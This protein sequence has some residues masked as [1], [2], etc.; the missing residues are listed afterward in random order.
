M[1]VL[2]IKP[3]P[4]TPI[5]LEKWTNVD[6]IY[7][8]F[9]LWPRRS[10]Y[11]SRVSGHVTQVGLGPHF[12]SLDKQITWIWFGDDLRSSWICWFFDD[13][14][15]RVS[16][17]SSVKC[18]GLARCTGNMGAVFQK[19]PILW[20]LH[21]QQGVGFTP[22]GAK[23]TTNKNKIRCVAALWGET[24]CFERMLLRGEWPDW[25]VQAEKMDR[26]T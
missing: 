11:T 3:N 9:S 5:P 13:A 20:N 23:N 21:T 24:L 15:G 4:C 7:S 18:A 10:A 2:Q 17:T 12:S 22:K 19:L 8:L 26:V 16:K 14:V 25:T 6:G 1:F